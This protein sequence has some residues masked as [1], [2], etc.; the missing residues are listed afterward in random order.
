MVY[1][2]DTSSFIVLSHYFPDRFPTFWENLNAAVDAEAVLSVREVFNELDGHMS[3]EHLED[4]VQSN[5][6]I[7]RTPSSEEASFVAEIFSVPH[8]QFLVTETQRLKGSP[9]ADPFV[10]ASAKIRGGC[11]VT[12]EAKKPNAARIPNVCEHFD[13][14][15]CNLEEFMSRSKWEY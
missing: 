6:S 10:V 7:F 2:F 1:V 4:W 5:K 3:K 15:C 14:D 12:E 13:V 11:V 9:V 8:L